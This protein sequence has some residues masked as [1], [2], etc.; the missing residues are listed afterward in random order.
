VKRNS[1][2]SY[3]HG[4]HLG[5]TSVATNAS[6]A[7]TSSVRYYAYG[8]QRGTG[9]IFALPTDHAFTGQKLDKGT[10]LLYYGARYYDSA[11][12]VFIS[13]DSIVPQPGDPLS[14][15]RYIYT[16]NNPLKYTDPSG[17]WGEIPSVNGSIGCTG[18]VG[19]GTATSLAHPALQPL[20][21]SIPN[22][23]RPIMTADRTTRPDDGFLLQYRNL[24]HVNRREE[25]AA[26]TPALPLPGGVGSVQAQVRQVTLYNDLLSTT[27]Q[28][29]YVENSLSSGLGVYKFVEVGAEYASGA[30]RGGEGVAPYV[31]VG[32]LQWQPGQIMLNFA[33]PTG[34]PGGGIGAQYQ[35]PGNMLFL[36]SQAQLDQVG[37]ERGFTRRYASG[38]ALLATERKTGYWHNGRWVSGVEVWR[39][40]LYRNGI[41][42][43]EER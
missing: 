16:L 10:G 15:N 37:G 6:G 30:G 35:T 24:G 2:L 5:S 12:G 29:A 38:Y 27:V 18:F 39:N 19:A 40:W 33:P 8:G 28:D 43:Y 13:P 11:L 20:T 31:Q 36:T 22:D 21:I 4:D 25:R 17:H 9:S 34:G 14:L 3:L 42:R 41:E 1:T 26:T 23:E 32:P 7:A